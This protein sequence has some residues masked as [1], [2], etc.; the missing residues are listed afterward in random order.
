MSNTQYDLIVI[1][2]GPAGEGAAMS[3]VKQGW[4]VAVV[5][6]RAMAGGNC[7]HLGTI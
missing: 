3:A 5:D 1:G 7:T 6:E 2:S 4:R